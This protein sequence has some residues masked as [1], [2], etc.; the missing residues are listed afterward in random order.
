MTA[1]AFFSSSGILLL[2]SLSSTTILTGNGDTLFQGLYNYISRY[3]ASTSADLTLS[4]QSITIQLHVRSIFKWF[5]HYTPPYPKLKYS[6]F[7]FAMTSYKLCTTIPKVLNQHCQ[8]IQPMT[9]HHFACRGSF[10]LSCFQLP[11]DFP[12]LLPPA[13]RE[14]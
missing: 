5:L 10:H 11:L 1:P 13:C 3:G 2:L 9:R 6:R 8:S 4:Y 14:P 12:L 7:Y